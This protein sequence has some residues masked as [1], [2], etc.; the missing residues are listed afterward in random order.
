MHIYLACGMNSLLIYFKLGI[1]GPPKLCY[2][3]LLSW[4]PLLL[5]QALSQVLKSSTKLQLNCC[6]LA[7][8][9]H[10]P[11][12]ANLV[13]Q[14]PT[15]WNGL[16]GND[17]KVRRPLA[18]TTSRHGY[19]TGLA[20]VSDFGHLDSC[21]NQIDCVTIYFSWQRNLYSQHIQTEG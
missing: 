13:N 15:P 17:F 9:Q 14:G 16:H 5:F 11:H 21:L 6:L 1:W 2:S 19:P 3:L 7:S 8:V 12:Q 10:S 18:G 20:Y 4:K